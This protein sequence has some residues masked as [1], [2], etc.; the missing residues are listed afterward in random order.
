MVKFYEPTN[1]GIGQ[2]IKQML[3]SY[4]KVRPGIQSGVEEG[5]GTFFP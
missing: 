4:I 3:T 1:S 5:H 2:E